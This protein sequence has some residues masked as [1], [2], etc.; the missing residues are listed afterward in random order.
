MTVPDLYTDD[1]TRT[2]KPKRTWIPRET[3]RQE[4]AV[5]FARD[6]IAC[7]HKFMAHDRAQNSGKEHLWQ[8]K[9]GVLKGTPDT[10]LIINGRH[11]WFEFKSKGNKPDYDQFRMLS[12]LEA[13]GDAASWGITIMDLCQ[14]YEDEGVPL[15]ANARYR[16]LVLDGLVDSRIAKEEAKAGAPAK[17]SRARKSA[18]R[19]A[20]GKGMQR[21]AAKAGI[22]FG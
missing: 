2:L 16:A 18:P 10:Q 6:A 3:Y 4:K 20:A 15:V 9:R 13:L 8:A 1:E 19:Y 5:V 7:R 21:R 14:F 22:A 11:L 12:D 17:P